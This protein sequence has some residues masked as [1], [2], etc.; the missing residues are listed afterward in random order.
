MSAFTITRALQWWRREQPN[1]IAVHYE[2][3]EITFA[4]LYDWALRIADYLRA[5]GVKP[6]DRVSGVAENSIQYAALIVG[7]VLCGAI[8]A[9]ISFRSS[10]R[11]LRRA[12]DV[13]TPTLVFAD[14]TRAP[15]AEEA[16][17]SKEA[18]KLRALDEVRAVRSA[19]TAGAVHLSAP[20]DPLFIISTSG[21]TGEPK[22]VVYTHRSF[23]TYSAEFAL[24]EPECCNGGSVFATGPFSSSSGTILLLQFLATGATVYSQRH[25]N[26]ADA[27]RLI[28]EKQIRVFLASTIFFERIAALPE[29]ATADL[30]CLKFAQIGGARVNPALL[31]RYR[32]RGVILRQAYG[33]TEAGGA[34]A[35]RDE[36]ALTEPE[37]C[38]SGAMFTEFAIAGENGGLAPAGVPGEILIRSAC[39]SAGYWNNEKATAEAFRDGWLHTGDRGVL[40]E[41]GNL[42][43]IDRIKDIIISGGLNISAMEVESVVAEAPGVQEVAVLSAQDDQ[44]GETPMAVVY[45]DEKAIDVSAIIAH[46]NAHLA[47]FKVPRYIAVEA[48]P[49][50]RLPSGKISKVM[51]RRKYENAHTFLPKVR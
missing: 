47:N 20:D 25:F 43:F 41:R 27:L 42:T 1:R 32:E 38:G 16:L 17:E 44:F 37:K 12:L 34:W 49:L 39:L 36:T 18:S 50:P 29:F 30:S 23:M 5:N 48:D 3:E 11:E 31:A 46:C 4:E 14:E 24:M 35:A 19:S 28:Q 2:G 33:C 22:G 13:L 45:G 6:G 8:H 51:L 7:V 21:S 10:A 9:P 40:D 26:A 15:V